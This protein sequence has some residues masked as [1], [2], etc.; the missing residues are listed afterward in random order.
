MI[1]MKIQPKHRQT[2]IE[3]EQWARKITGQ[4]KNERSFNIPDE[5]QGV[6]VAVDYYC[7]HFDYCCVPNCRLG[8]DCYLDIDCCA[9]ESNQW[10]VSK[11]IQI[12]SD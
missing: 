3:Q 1:A 5:D 2:E 12:K 8:F 7:E 9:V 4:K 10:N 11:R 6:V